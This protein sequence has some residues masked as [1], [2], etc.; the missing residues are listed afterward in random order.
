MEGSDVFQW[1]KGLPSKDLSRGR[2]KE[3]I[4]ITGAYNV[5]DC[6]RAR[7]NA[8]LVSTQFVNYL[9]LSWGRFDEVVLIGR[10][11]KV[12]LANAVI[13]TLRIDDPRTE[14]IEL[15]KTSAKIAEIFEPKRGNK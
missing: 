3:D 10:F 9:D 14:I 7:F 4:E 12:D 15:D 11:N 6:W 13:G 1:L 2:T 8:L 5:V